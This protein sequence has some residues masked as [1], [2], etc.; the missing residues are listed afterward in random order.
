MAVAMSMA[1]SMACSKHSVGS[2]AEHIIMSKST[3]NAGQSSPPISRSSTA[4]TLKQQQESTASGSELVPFADVTHDE[5]VARMKPATSP[6][7]TRSLSRQN[8]THGA[9]QRQNSLPPPPAGTVDWTAPST[10]KQPAG[11]VTAAKNQ[12]ACGA[13]WAFG[14][15]GAMESFHAIKTGQLVNA[16]VQ[17]ILECQFP[18]GCA[19]G[20]PRDA[21]FFAAA[22]GIESSA[23]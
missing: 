22:N 6:P 15:T 19:G 3:P 11:C 1:M 10:C 14:A 13:C 18:K 21:F 4:T 2:T 16:S 8:T 23:D 5:F 12:G 7:D 17:E 20:D 9:W